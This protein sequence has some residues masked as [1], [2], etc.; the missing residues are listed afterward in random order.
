MKHSINKIFSNLSLFLIIITLTSAV[1]TLLIL[2][3]NLTY[4]KINNLK[5][6]K[7][8]INSLAN[9][10]KDDIELALI[11]F[12][13]KSTQLQHETDKLRNLN[14]YDY[15]SKFIFNNSDEYLSDLDNLSKLTTRF[16][17]SAHAYYIKNL[18]NEEEKNQELINSF[19]SI[20]L[21][22]D[23][24]IIKNSQYNEEKFHI[25]EKV[26]VFAFIL[27]LFVTLWYRKRL[28][29]IYTD[30]LYLYAIDKNKKDYEI[31]SEEADAIK[32]RMSR[33]PATT[34]NPAMVDPVTQINNHKGMLSAYANKK[35]MKDSNFTSVTIFEI[36]NFSKQNRAFSQEFTQAI[37]KKVAFTISLHEQATDVIARTDYNQFTV[38][39]SRASKE[40]S[41]KDIDIIRQSI[42]EIK[43]K[44]PG[45]SPITITVSGGFIIKPNNQSLEESLRQAKEVLHH[46]KKKGKNTISQ[47][48]DLAEHE[49]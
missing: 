11:Q 28:N 5:N 33:K 49:L 21:F 48:R 42:S 35:G 39:L 10:Q 2:E 37:L 36:D 43:F 46:S 44:A 25:V 4:S 13:G 16:N 3:Q 23:S 15:T 47:I 14:K 17:E 41:F 26:T 29:S 27:M 1:L 12:N 19:N 8:I 6:Q 34:E 45:G 31:F 18:K 9:L 24:M 20:N 40:Q 32:L 22:L 7:V 38:I 30:I